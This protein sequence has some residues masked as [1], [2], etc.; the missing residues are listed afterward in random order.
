MTPLTSMPHTI[1]KMENIERSKQNP[2]LIYIVREIFPEVDN[3]GNQG[4]L[5]KILLPGDLGYQTM[6][7]RLKRREEENEK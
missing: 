6:D 1:T 5:Y 7:E 4:R 2:R 3:R